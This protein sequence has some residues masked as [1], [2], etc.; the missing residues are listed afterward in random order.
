LARHVANCVLRES[1]SGTVITK[2]D[3]ARKIDA[4]V[5]TVVAYERAMWHTE[6][7]LDVPWVEVIS[8]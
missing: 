1:S 5:A 2:P 7:E 8:G 4:A 6:R 3:P